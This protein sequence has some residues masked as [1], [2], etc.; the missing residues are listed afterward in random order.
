MDEMNFLT[1]NGVPYEVADL[2]ARVGKADIAYV[3]KT[4]APAIPITLTGTSIITDM[5]CPLE[6]DVNCRVES[7]NLLNPTYWAAR[8]GFTVDDVTQKIQVTKATTLRFC[9]FPKIPAGEKLTLS[10]YCETADTNNFSVYFLDSKNYS[11]GGVVL[12]GVQ[13]N[14][15]TEAVITLD[16][17]VYGI[18]GY[19]SGARIMPFFRI[20]FGRYEA[21]QSPYEFYNPDLSAVKVTQNPGGKTFTLS[22]SGEVTGM[23][24]IYPSMTILTDNPGATVTATYNADTKKY[25]DSKFAEL[26]ALALRTG[27]VQ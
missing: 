25:I 1:M 14:T 11:A 16:K 15:I 23:K 19:I 6:H 20:S 18:G 24:S 7:K 3:N 21:D 9:R 17:D 4:F 5:V 8:L 27:G 12:K 10:V 13:S 22:P 2:K 26:Q